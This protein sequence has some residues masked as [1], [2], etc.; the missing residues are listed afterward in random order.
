MSAFLF[1][2][3]RLHSAAHAARTLAMLGL[4]I[5]FSVL[6]DLSMKHGLDRTG[7]FKQ[8]GP[9]AVLRSVYRMARNAWVLL[10][11][12]GMTAAFFTLLVL[13][14]AA[15]ASAVIPA[16]AATFVLETCGARLILKERVTPVRWIGA[17]LVAVGVA[18]VA[19]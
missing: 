6:G 8:L 11:L 15:P 14:S 2:V 4:V 5:V 1:A 10:G 16:T 9:R 3:T 7:G 19:R 17:A 18:L 13:L 12:S